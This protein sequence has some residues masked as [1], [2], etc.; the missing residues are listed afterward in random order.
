MFGICIVVTVPFQ[1]SPTAT[2]PS[3]TVAEQAT[4]RWRFTLAYS[5]PIALSAGSSKALGRNQGKIF[6]QK[7]RLSLKL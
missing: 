2:L 4:R 6:F 7:K 1:A 5:V 3:D